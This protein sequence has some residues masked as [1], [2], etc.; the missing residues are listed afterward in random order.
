MH[1]DYYQNTLYPLQDKVLKLVSSVENRFYL[2]GGTALSRA[3]LHHR[4]SDD[5]DFFV[6]DDENFK[7][8]VER[9]YSAF[10]K[11]GLTVE[12]ASMH[13]SHARWFVVEE[14]CSLKIDF[15][16]DIGYRSGESKQTPLFIRTDTIRNILSN[17]LTALG[18]LEAKDVIDILYIAR[19]MRFQ[20]K[21]IFSE[22]DKKDLWV[23]P[24]ETASLLDK[25]PVNKADDIAWAIP[26]PDDA[27]LKQ[28]IHTLIKD[29]LK[30][31]NNSLVE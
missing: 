20:W 10:I 23:N 15:V 24:V 8:Q 4:Y 7:K 11:S 18:R 17:K 13:E 19:N 27:E 25:F 14:E 2:T 29:I 26:K 31:N 3:Y 28:W 16:N 12:T 6:N 21:E 5:L 22:A 30:G 1:D 9:I